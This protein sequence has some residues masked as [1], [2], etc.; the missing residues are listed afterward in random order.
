MILWPLYIYLCYHQSIL[1]LLWFDNFMCHYTIIE[2]LLHINIP[3]PLYISFT[4]ISLYLNIL[5]MITLYTITP[6]YNHSIFM[7][8]LYGHCIYL[9]YHH[10]INNDIMTSLFMIILSSAYIYLYYYMT[11]LCMVILSL[12]HSISIQYSIF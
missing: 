2:P 11:T 1:N 7:N 4:L 6:R 8:I 12:D 10:S 3:W 5:Y 9:Y